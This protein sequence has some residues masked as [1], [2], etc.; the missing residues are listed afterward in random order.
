MVGVKGWG[1]VLVPP[2]CPPLLYGPVLL[3][4]RVSAGALSYYLGMLEKIQKQVNCATDPTFADSLAL[5]KIFAMWSVIDT[6]LEDAHMMSLPPKEWV[7][8]F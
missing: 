1:G 6:H 5:Q 7:G 2:F 3:C 4:Y 8:L